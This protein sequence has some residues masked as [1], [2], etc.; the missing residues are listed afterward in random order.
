MNVAT[1]AASFVAARTAQ[2]QLA[3]ASAMMRMNAEQEA[4]VANLLAAASENA[5]EMASAVEGLGA[6]L[7][8]RV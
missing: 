8:I 4:S 2:I 1:L 7:D 3:V 6:N 5:Q